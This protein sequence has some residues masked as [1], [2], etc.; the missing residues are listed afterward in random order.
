MEV[1]SWSGFRQHS[2]HLKTGEPAKDLEPILAAVL[3]DGIILG[4]SEME[5]RLGG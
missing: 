1:A 4:L 3:A 2:R 5:R